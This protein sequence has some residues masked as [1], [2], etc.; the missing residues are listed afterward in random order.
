LKEVSEAAPTR[1][2]ALHSSLREDLNLVVI[3]LEDDDDAQEIFETLNALGTPLLPADLV[4]NYL[5]RLAGM[6]GEDPQKLYVQYWKNFDDEKSYW[7]KEIRQGRL[8]RARLD[9]FLNNYLTMLKGEEVIISQMFLDYRDMV[10]A[11]NGTVITQHLKTFNEYA[12]VYE[13]FDH[14]LAGSREKLFFYRLR[15]LDTTTVFPLLL[16][17]FKRHSNAS[18]IQDRN[19]ILTDLESFLVRRAVCGLTT[20]GYNRLFAQLVMKLRKASDDFSAAA[21]RQELVSETADT[22]RWPD[23]AEFM[24]AW[25]T[26][27]FYKR[28]RKSAQRMILEAIEESLHTGKTEKFDLERTL[29]IEHLLPRD[30]EAH[31]PLVVREQSAESNEQARERR[32]LSI[33]RIGNL[34]L[35]TKELNPA[36]SNGP[37]TK[38]RDKILEHSALNLNRPFYNVPVWD[39]DLIE[40]RSTTLGASA[41]KIWPHP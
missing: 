14:F 38:K 7:R 11:A 15:E 26:I 41:I 39:E 33:H 35:L 6:Q 8:K 21:L 19:Q 25:T 36:I 18:D 30:W 37:W 4:K 29:T 23:D 1:L 5:F 2:H 31:W 17:I 16:E 24:H 32:D 22:Q 40:R 3:D 9:L 28:V 20:K 27:D 34:T 10:N 13:S 12:G